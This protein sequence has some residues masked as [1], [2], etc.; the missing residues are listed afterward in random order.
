MID[1][2][3]ALRSE[4]AVHQRGGD[5][6]VGARHGA[7]E[8]VRELGLVRGRGAAGQ[9]GPGIGEPAR[10]AAGE[11][12][13]GGVDL[14]TLT[15]VAGA[16]RSHLLLRLVAETE[17]AQR[18]GAQAPQPGAHGSPAQ[19]RPGGGG[20]VDGRTTPGSPAASAAR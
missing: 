19:A 18:V 5:P 9:R 17:P 10:G 4:P 16:A 15:G 20:R 2:N 8:P 1:A 3:S 7:V 12:A 14:R 6:Q 13:D 11:R